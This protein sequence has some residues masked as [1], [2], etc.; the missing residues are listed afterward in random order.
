MLGD[1]DQS[2]TGT[3][4]SLPRGPGEQP[5]ERR[6][7]R[8]A[9]LQNMLSRTRSTKM[10]QP[11]ATRNPPKIKTTSNRIINSRS[12]ERRDPPAPSQ[13]MPHTAPLSPERGFRDA[14][15]SSTRNRSADR[16]INRITEE[17]SR[18]QPQQG[19]GRFQNFM[20]TSTQAAG[21]I[22]RAG[23]GFM[24]KFTRSGSTNE[25]EEPQGEYVLK[26]IRQPLIVQVRATRLRSRMAEA[27]DKT[28]Y[29]LPAL[30]YRCIE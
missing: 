3:G 7:S 4:H 8:H 30:P 13:D 24:S 6:P 14:M 12:R 19:P 29:W 23:K 18:L 17:D 11:P 21:Q 25:R 26:L 1:D 10:D 20:T 22:G 16:D 28:E 27:R 2:E 9:Y 15:Q 5:R